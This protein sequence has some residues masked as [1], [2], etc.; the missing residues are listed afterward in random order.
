MVRSGTLFEDSGEAAMKATRRRTRR[1]DPL[2]SRAA[3][4]GLI[5]ELRE[6]LPE[7]I[8]SSD[9]QLLSLLR[10]AVYA[11]RHPELR[12]RKGRKSIW[13]DY[14]L[15]IAAQTMREMLDRG[16]HQVSLRSFVEHYLLIPGFPDDVARALESGEINLFEAEQLARLS[17]SQTGIAG[18]TL[19]R[20][21]QQLLRT[22]LQS[23][24]S[25]VRLKARVDDL[26]SH[27][28]DSGAARETRSEAAR[29]SDQVL[30]AAK[31]LEAELEE[32][33][34][35][36]ENPIAGIGPEHFFYEYLQI[37][38]AMMREINPDEIA[39]PTLDRLMALS[40]QLIR[41]LNAI[42]KQQY[43]SRGESLTET[44]D[45]SVVMTERWTHS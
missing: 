6:A 22:H 34:E 7:Q 37:I 31:Q 19:K 9:R 24:E 42:Y 44:R 26:L 40:E 29:H 41:Q 27:Y 18:E 43:P 33:A 8:P 38:A 12:S 25:G 28:R 39:E 14:Q 2:A 15:I 20:R 32:A 3:I 13:K 17:P 4:R 21:R 30:S 5:D 45:G 10:A 35:T 1:P 16:T 11:E 36:P 23:A